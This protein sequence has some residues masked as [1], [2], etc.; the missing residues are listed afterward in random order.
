MDKQVLVS[1]TGLQFSNDDRNAVEM[2]T[3]GD[4]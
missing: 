2:I 4:Y 1:I 3:V